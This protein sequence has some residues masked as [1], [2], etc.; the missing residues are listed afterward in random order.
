MAK[1]ARDVVAAPEAELKSHQTL[2]HGSFDFVDADNSPRH[3]VPHSHFGRRSGAR[4]EHDFKPNQIGH[5]EAASSRGEKFGN[6]DFMNCRLDNNS[7]IIIAWIAASS[8]TRVVV[9][10]RSYYIKK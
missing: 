10:L 7:L 1:T 5:L 4:A 6:P 3:A 8:R 2:W 9:S